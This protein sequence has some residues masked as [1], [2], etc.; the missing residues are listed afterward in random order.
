M[1]L[2]D[3]TAG[4]AVG[5]FKS[6]KQKK[7]IHLL[8]SSQTTTD[9]QWYI[10]RTGK[11]CHDCAWDHQTIQHVELQQTLHRDSSIVG[12][13]EDLLLMWEGN[14]RLWK[15]EDAICSSSWRFLCRWLIEGQ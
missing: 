14:I 11:L 12:S 2:A 9:V 1:G 15:Y 5:T 10:I 8:Q 7:R 4:G 13:G 3:C 6:Q